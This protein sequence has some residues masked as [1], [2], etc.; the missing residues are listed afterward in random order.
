MT[1]NLSAEQ[2]M[3]RDSTRQLAS[4]VS[5]RATRDLIAADDNV[6][7]S[8]QALRHV[9]ESGLGGI[10]V[11]EAS[12]GASLDMVTAALAARELGRKLVVSPLLGAAVGAYTLARFADEALSRDWLARIAQGEATI[13]LALENHE[14]P[15][16]QLSGQ[17]K[18]NGHAQWAVDA[19]TAD[20]L[21]VAASTP[22][23][24]TLI[25]VPAGQGGLSKQV[26]RM[27]DGRLLATLTFSDVDLAGGADLGAEALDQA[28]RVACV[29]LAA[30]TCGM[31][32][33]SFERTV[34]YLR[35]RR[36]FDRAIAS[37]QAIQHR[38]AQM[39]CDIEDAWSATQHAAMAIDTADARAALHVAVAKAKTSDVASDAVAECLQLHGGIG[40][41]EEHDVG[42]YLKAARLSSELLGGYSYHADRV[43]TELG[44]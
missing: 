28:F 1:F 10:L 26:T 14:S 39:H 27:A 25:F 24:S 16:L 32:E 40:M 20:A 18:L 7:Y 5:P 19:V 36:Q 42:L 17:G 33:E 44:Y 8:D 29:W 30:N 38:L 6:A 35:D 13:G 34:A 31:V 3:V 43:A 9:A 2:A 22:N 37:F 21:M 4:A 15:T 12:G 41:T 23:G 11:P